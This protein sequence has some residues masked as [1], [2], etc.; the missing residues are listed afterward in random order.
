M[1]LHSNTDKEI[2]RAALM[3]FETQREQIDAK[4]LEVQQRLEA[5]KLEPKRGRPRKDA[6]AT[7]IRAP[8]ERHE[9]RAKR[10]VPLSARRKM[11]TAQKRR[12]ALQRAQAAQR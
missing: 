3:G 9:H 8:L 10:H 12:W 2:L 11:A 4:I 1:T 7:V 6:Q 5:Q